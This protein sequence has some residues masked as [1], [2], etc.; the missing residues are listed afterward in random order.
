M[1]LFVDIQ[2]FKDENNKFILKELAILSTENEFQHFIVKPPYEFKNLPTAQQNQV[3]WLCK[4]HYNFKWESGFIS[5]DNLVQHLSLVLSGK[6]I[7]VKG[8][9]KIAWLKDIFIHIHSIFNLEDYGYPS[10]K[11][12]RNLFP[13]SRKCL[14]HNG[15]AC[16]QKNV[17][18][19]YNYHL[20]N[21]NLLK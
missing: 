21:P 18:L 6:I 16:A 7:Y 20:C 19:F 4:N 10:I 3:R 2:G 14:L 17:N 1:W 11:D 15:S 5:L 8:T 12:L 9:E 13:N